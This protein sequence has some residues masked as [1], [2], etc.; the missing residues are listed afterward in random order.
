VTRSARRWLALGLSTGV[1][2]VAAWVLVRRGVLG[3]PG[4]TGDLVQFQDSANAIDRLLRERAAAAPPPVER[5]DA[6]AVLVRE[7][8]PEED[9]R[10]LFGALET[11]A[12][13]HLYD[14]FVYYRFRPGLDRKVPLP[15]HPD[16][17]IVV[18]TNSIGLRQDAEL[19]AEPPDLR[20]LVIGDSHTGGACNN[21]EVFSAVLERRLAAAFPERSVEVLNTGKAGY[22]FYHYLGALE[23]WSELEP[24][25]AVVAVY[26]GNDFVESLLL[27]HYFQRTVWP[28]TEAERAHKKEVAARFPSGVLAQSMQQ[29]SYFGAHPEE[30]GKAL[31]SALLT[32]LAMDRFA[33]E[34]GIALHVVLIPAMADVQPERFDPELALVREAFGLPRDGPSATAELSDAWIAALSEHGI[35]VLDLRPAFRAAE[36]ALYWPGD[37]HLDLAGE[38]LVGAALFEHLAPS[39]R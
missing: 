34:R 2:L 26:A 3:P 16:G 22:S 30:R 32:T 6:R 31:D 11:A 4:V 25:V 8:V 19:R 21:D 35:A 24:D 12:V 7:T 39:V 20:I 17:H 27:H 9:A 18:R 33:A 29:E 38:A 15:Q 5:A 14:P 37:H 36:G 23:K 1:C 28:A 13:A 10:V